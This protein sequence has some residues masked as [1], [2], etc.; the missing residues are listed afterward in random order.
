MTK[1]RST[2]HLRWQFGDQLSL[3]TVRADVSHR[4]VV[5]LCNKLLLALDGG[6]R[7]LTLTSKSSAVSDEDELERLVLALFIRSERAL[8]SSYNLSLIGYYT[9]AI[10]LAR[11]VHENML[12]LW[13]VVHTPDTARSLLVNDEDYWLGQPHDPAQPG[14]A[15]NRTLNQI[16][17]DVD[18]WL[19][20][21]HAAPGDINY[22]DASYGGMSGIANPRGLA[23]HPERTVVKARSKGASN[24]A[25]DPYLCGVAL[26]V[27]TVEARLTL[28]Q[29]DDRLVTKKGTQRWRASTRSLLHDVAAW[30]EKDGIRSQSR[31]PIDDIRTLGW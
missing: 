7:H 29:L 31:P 16:A 15:K 30:V 20:T 10:I 17:R 2:D 28:A 8:I 11:S 25:W 1:E 27:T 18:R 26:R 12:V 3:N 9:P 6:L 4:A 23:L 19:T 13:D 14:V 5:A 21:A 22:W 24:P